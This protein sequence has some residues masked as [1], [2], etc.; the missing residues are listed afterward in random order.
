MKVALINIL[1]VAVAICIFVY[2]HK[3]CEEL[4]YEK[5]F[6]QKYFGTVEW[7]FLDPESRMEPYI[8]L[9]N[10]SKYRLANID[11]YNRLES[12]DTLFKLG[13]GMKFY[14][15]KNGDTT[16]FYQKCKKREMTD[17]VISRRVKI[18]AQH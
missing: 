5:Y 13:G 16:I 17:E 1:I 15:V 4:S 11:I 6:S 2:F 12:G 7:K 9:S 10:G 8:V 18:S 14:Y 3:S